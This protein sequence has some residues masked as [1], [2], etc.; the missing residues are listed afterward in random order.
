VVILALLILGAAYPFETTVV[1]EWK[2]RIVDE[3]GSSFAGARVVQQWD[4]YSLGIGG[5]EETWANED[6]YVVF[7][8][9]TVRSSLLYRMLRIS[10]AVLMKL[11]H[12]STGIRATVW[13]TTPRVASDSVEYEAGKPLPQV[14][15]LRR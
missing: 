12:G 15:V 10:W 14:I 9:R 11:A 3:A 1:P 13:G 4:H 5:G 7:P 2:I 8:K 6:G